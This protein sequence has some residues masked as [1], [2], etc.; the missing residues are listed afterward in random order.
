MAAVF[1]SYRHDDTRATTYRLADSLRS[2]FDK[3][4]VFLDVESIVPGKPFAEAIQFSLN[5]SSV[6]LIMI[7]KNWLDISDDE[8]ARRL[9]DP[10]DWVRQ[11]VRLAL[12]SNC[13]VIPV[14]VEGA[15]MPDAETLPDDMRALSSLH[16]FTFSDQQAHW[17]FDVNRLSQMI[18]QHDKVLSKKLV[19]ASKEGT[20]KHLS[21][22]KTVIAGLIITCLFMVTHASE[23]WDNTDELLGYISFY[24]LG[25]ILCAIGFRNIRKGKSKGKKLAITGIVLAILNILAGIG[26]YPSESEG[27]DSAPVVDADVVNAPEYQWVDDSQ[28]VIQ[29]P[30]A[31]P[32]A[33]VINIEGNWV[34]DVGV[35]YQMTQSGN[36]V[37]FTETNVF[38][39]EVGFG[40]GLIIDNMFTFEYSSTL[41]GIKGLGV[42]HIN[43]IGMVV[44]FTD[45]DGNALDFNLYPE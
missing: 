24:V 39:S 16:A 12:A 11:E 8:G 21:W 6:V 33:N 42:G 18:A 30:V 4:N 5:K 26:E 31:P 19:A 15:A 43:E 17:A 35:V 41:T 37:T 27:F 34:S 3:D 7:G 1:M 23:G 14:L 36:E 32:A 38:G 40:K 2:N 22:S 9:D 45:S 44:N 28:Q 13:Q 20:T 10:K 29:E 25:L